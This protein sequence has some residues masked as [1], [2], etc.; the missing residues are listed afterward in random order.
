MAPRALRESGMSQTTGP[1]E[2]LQRLD[3]ATHQVAGRNQQH[4]HSH[5]INNT[6]MPHTSTNL[7]LPILASATPFAP[8]SSLHMR[9]E[10]LNQGSPMQHASG[11]VNG[12][13]QHCMLRTENPHTSKTDHPPSCVVPNPT[14]EAALPMM[15]PHQN[16]M[17][18]SI[19]SHASSLSPNFRRRMPF[20][21]SSPMAPPHVPMSRDHRGSFMSRPVATPAT[22]VPERRDIWTMKPKPPEN[23]RG[24]QMELSSNM[25]VMSSDLTTFPPTNRVGSLQPLPVD[26][27]RPQEKSKSEA[28]KTDTTIALQGQAFKGQFLHRQKE[29]KS[30]GDFK[31]YDAPSTTVDVNPCKR[32]A[33]ALSDTRH[34]PEADTTISQEQTASSGTMGS[35]DRVSHQ[36][37]T[38]PPMKMVVSVDTPSPYAAQMGCLAHND[39]STPIVKRGRGRPRKSQTKQAAIPSAQPKAVSAIEPQNQADEAIEDPTVLIRNIGASVASPQTQPPRRIEVQPRSEQCFI[40]P[41]LPCNKLR[42]PL[43]PQWLRKAKMPHDPPLDCQ[44]DLHKKILPADHQIFSLS[45]NNMTPLRCDENRCLF[46]GLDLAECLIATRDAME[47]AHELG[48]PERHPPPVHGGPVRP[49]RDHHRH[50]SNDIKT[51]SPTP[52]VCTDCRVASYMHLWHTRRALFRHS[53]LPLCHKCGDAVFNQIRVDEHHRDHRERAARGECSPPNLPAPRELTDYAMPPAFHYLRWDSND[54][55]DLKPYTTPEKSLAC[56]DR[57]RPPQSYRCQIQGWQCHDCLEKA[58]EH[59]RTIF[60]VGYDYRADHG[61]RCWCGGEIDSQKASV[62]ICAGCGGLEMGTWTPEDWKRAERV[63]KSEVVEE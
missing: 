55:L 29:Q 47:E 62:L 46:N 58:L 7:A 40:Q 11:D 63:R 23:Q 2:S 22:F 42:N 61:F 12:P 54:T 14:T 50:L 44:I 57:G 4:S 41:T 18:S 45:N 56:L 38:Q 15:T 48:L 60:E 49:C 43:I 21:G 6:F 25:P 34:E 37:Q 17:L 36:G 16:S 8:H 9:S 31:T 52:N 24:P 30:P 27:K 53:F 19:P 26:D 28:A 1:G 35:I 3:T 13:V 33:S 39:T 32:K 51:S 59:H 20:P 10:T 5:V